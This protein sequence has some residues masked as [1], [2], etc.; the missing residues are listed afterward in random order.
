LWH[1]FEGDFAGRHI[2]YGVDGSL[3][4]LRLQISRCQKLAAAAER[5]AARWTGERRKKYLRLAKEW[6][7]RAT[8]IQE[9]INAGRSDSESPQ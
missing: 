3:E 4:Q 2:K 9:L 8:E 7:G 1:V 5:Q 6:H